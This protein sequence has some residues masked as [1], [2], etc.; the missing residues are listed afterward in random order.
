MHLHIAA[1]NHFDVLGRKNLKRWLDNLRESHDASPAFVA[2]E[3]TNDAFD[4]IKIQRGTVPELARLHWPDAPQEL[5]AALPRTLA[6]E[7]DTHLE[8]FAQPIEVL[9]LGE[10]TTQKDRDLI[11]QFACRHLYVYHRYWKNAGSPPSV[12]DALAAMGRAPWDQ[13]DR[14]DQR[15]PPKATERDS[16]LACAIIERANQ[17][18]QQWAIAVLGAHHAIDRPGFTLRRLRDAGIPCCVHSLDPR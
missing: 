7:A 4:Q 9:W 12:P 15:D 14:E 2:Q 11:P 16:Q 10:F 8:V 6:Y 18:A 5:I 3:Y 17:P 1:V 13:T